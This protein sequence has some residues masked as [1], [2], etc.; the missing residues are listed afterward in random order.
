MKPLTLDAADH[1]GPEWLVELLRELVRIDSSDP[2]GNEIRVAEVVAETLVRNG[3]DATLDEFQRG[4]ANVMARIKGRTGSNALVFSAHLDTVPAGNELWKHPPFG[5]VTI[6]GRMYGRGTADMKSGLAAMIAAALAIN[7]R[8]DRLRA[9]LVLAFTAGESSACLGARRLVEQNA[10]IGA[11]AILV[12]EPTSLRLVTAEKGAMWLRATTSGQSGHIS[13]MLSARGRGANA[14]LPM[15]EFLT[16]LDGYRFD[17][18]PHP[19]LGEPTINIGKISGGLAANLTPDKCT[20]D[21]DLRLL[22]AQGINE[23]VAEVKEVAGDL[24]NISLVDWKPPVVTEADHPFV[25]LCA[26]ALKAHL[27]TSTDPLGVTY[28]SDAAVLAPAFDLAMVIIGPG[29]LGISGSLNEYVEID[30]VIG[31]A[32]VYAE[33]AFDYLK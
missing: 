8:K 20:A 19:L 13:G 31:A 32:K 4:R 10:L 12:S 18:P 33:I 9:D 14:I 5:G 22:P 6:D 28:Y 25:R 27:D 21:F 3:I 15:M 26:K 24:V 23:V 29:E 1:R 7:E 2:P 16:K 11:D 30:N 17:T